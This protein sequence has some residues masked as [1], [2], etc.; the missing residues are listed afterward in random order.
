MKLNKFKNFALSVIF[1]A[2]NNET[3]FAMTSG[4]NSTIHYEYIL[5][6]KKQMYLIKQSRLLKVG[7]T[8]EK[9]KAVLGLP[10]SDERELVGKKGEFIAL[11]VVYYFK[12]VDKNNANQ[13]DQSLRIIFNEKRKMVSIEVPENH[14]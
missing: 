9:V 3:C 2:A 14:E 10:V 13:F 1:I 5:Q 11:V 12:R 7:D 4:E 8:I 6:P